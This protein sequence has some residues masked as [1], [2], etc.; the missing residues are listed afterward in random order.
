MK[1]TTEVNIMAD[2][3]LKACKESVKF[4][5]ETLKKNPFEELGRA[6]IRAKQDVL[7]NKTMIQAYEEYIIENNLKWDE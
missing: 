3:S 6:I 2:F 1:H 4:S 7:F 5:V